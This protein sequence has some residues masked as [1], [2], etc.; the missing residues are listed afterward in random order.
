VVDIG[1]RLQIIP[2]NAGVIEQH[3]AVQ[4][5]KGVTNINKYL[6]DLLEEKGHY[7]QTAK[8]QEEV[9]MIKEKCCYVA[10]N[11]ERELMRPESEIVVPFKLRSGEVIQVGQERFKCPELLFNPAKLGILDASFALPQLITETIMKCDIDT[12]VNLL[13]NI[14]LVGGGTLI[15]GKSKKFVFFANCRRNGREVGRRS[16]PKPYFRLWHARSK[17]VQ[18]PLYL[19][20]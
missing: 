19:C 16:V 11:Y 4:L 10:L 5:K 1:N 12:R 20:P 6:S 3:A 18:H 13:S 15:P 17:E 14:M 8:E 7:F 2:V 9:R